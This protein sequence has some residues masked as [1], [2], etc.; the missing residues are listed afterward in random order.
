MNRL[1]LTLFL[2]LCL[3]SAKAQSFQCSDDLMVSEITKE[4]FDS[5]YTNRI[6]PRYPL[7]DHGVKWAAI[8]RSFVGTTL[9]KELESEWGEDTEKEG[10]IGYYEFQATNGKTNYI[11]VANHP[12]DPTAYLLDENYKA[13]STEMYGCG[14]LSNDLIFYSCEEFDC[15]EFVHCEWYSV[16]DG[17][18]KQIAELRDSSFDYIVSWSNQRDGLFPDNRGHYY[19]SIQNRMDETEKFY[20]LTLKS[21]P[22]SQLAVSTF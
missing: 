15:D 5:A 22:V 9:W 4:A 1:W 17:K 3:I 8:K 12:I 20:Q 10:F 11:L 19:L 6:K 21:D 14:E 13:D 18:V 2:L 16:K 7:K